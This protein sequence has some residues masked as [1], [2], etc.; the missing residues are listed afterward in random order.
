MNWEALG[1]IGEI[2][3][4]VAVIVTLAYLAVQIRQNTRVFRSSTEQAQ[5]DAHS[6]C[7]SLIA[8]DSDLTRL[9]LRGA[10]GESLDREESLRFGFLLHVVFIQIQ[11][12]FLHQRQGTL[13]SEQWVTVSRVASRWISSPG[14]RAWWAEGKAVY[15][16]EFVQ[17]VDEMI[18]PSG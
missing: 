10:S 2:V 5:A 9:Y 15:R 16:D 11:A 3:G 14:A 18:S 6:R 12:A 1:A 17:A 8:Q 13:S 4:A 7:L